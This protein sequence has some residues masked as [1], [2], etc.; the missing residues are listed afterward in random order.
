MPDLTV[1]RFVP[2]P[3]GRV[4]RAFTD[5]DELASWFW[6]PRLQTEARVEAVPGG[7]LRLRS[8][9]ADLG[10]TGRVS[11]A[12]EG[13]ML[14][15]SWRWDGED[16]ETAVTI[17]FADAAGGTRV[18]VRQEGLHDEEAVADHVNG[19]NDCL[20]RLVAMPLS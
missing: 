7:E 5:G 19:W 3:P 6:P 18:V 1:E 14:A 10:V 8:D 17:A 13:R 4:W 2:A 11:A 16:H 12:E 15:T 20:D 9:V